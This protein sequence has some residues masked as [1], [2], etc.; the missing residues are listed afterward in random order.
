MTG[1]SPLR[2]VLYDGRLLHAGLERGI[3]ESI[4]TQTPPSFLYGFVDLCRGG[5]C[6]VVADGRVPHAA[7]ATTE[8]QANAPMSALASPPSLYTVL[9]SFVQMCKIEGTYPCLVIDEATEAL[10]GRS[11][12]EK[13]AAV[14][15]LQSMTSFTKQRRLVNVILASSDHSESFRLNA[16]GYKSD[17][18]T[19]SVVVGE[20]SASGA[21]APDSTASAS[22]RSAVATAAA[23]CRSRRATCGSC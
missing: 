9:S 17:H 3:V 18:W 5:A 10:P 23:L 15:A 8:E 7:R 14:S 13:K 21:L 6:S 16:L 4:R 2:V 20:V 22:T 1:A 19:C 11:D 12:A